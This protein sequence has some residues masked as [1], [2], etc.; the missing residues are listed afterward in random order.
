MSQNLS[1]K[2]HQVIARSSEVI[3]DKKEQITNILICLLA[4][5][6]LLIEDQPGVGKTTLVQTIARL[7]GLKQNRIQFTND[8]LP[9]DIL[10]QTIFNPQKQEFTF[11]EGPIFSEVIIADE[12]N[13]ANPKT[14]SALLQVMEENQVTLDRTT[15]FL[16]E[17][18]FLMATQNPRSQIGTHPL[19]ESQVDRFLMS[20][21]LDFISEESEIEILKGENP[22]SKLAKLQPLTSLDEL[23]AAQAIV[24]KVH[25]DFKIAAYI[26]RILKH[27]RDHQ[28]D[29]APLSTRAGLSLID[30]CKAK[31][32]LNE[33]NFISP[34]DLLAVIKPVF[35]HRLSQQE[36]LRFG[37]QQVEKILQIHQLP[38]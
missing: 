19:P 36:G 20:M 2:F 15:Y 5:G 26:A 1:G 27:T 7:I 9:S 24:E 14:Q 22:R 6:H 4:N 32:F 23:I 13:R 30:A 12:L 21:H 37:E 17:V 3:L 29:F 38:N 8:L 34:D 11:K 35:G 16:P 31:A 18:F 28:Q 25:V 10:G 33:R